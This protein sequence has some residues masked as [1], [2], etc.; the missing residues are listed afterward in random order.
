MK[1]EQ[2]TAIVARFLLLLLAL[3]ACDGA[4][5]TARV[6]PLWGSPHVDRHHYAATTQS[7]VLQQNQQQQQQP[8]LGAFPFEQA[9]TAAQALPARPQAA[10][11]STHLLM[12]P[13]FSA[14]APSEPVAIDVAMTM[15]SRSH[16]FQ[17]QRPFLSLPLLFFGDVPSA[18]YD[19]DTNPIAA[20]DADGRSLKLVY[21]DKDPVFGP[22]V[23]YMD[24][25]ETTPSALEQVVVRFLA[26]YR[27]MENDTRSGARVDLRRDVS[28]TG[29]VGQGVSFIPVP[30]STDEDDD[31]DPV[32]GGDWDVT[33]EWDLR[34]APAQSANIRGAWSHGDAAVSV[35][36]GPLIDLV[37]NAI[38]A[39]GALRRY[40]DW[41]PPPPHPAAGKHVATGEF[42]VY[43]L[44]PAPLNVTALAVQSRI[45]H[46]RI[47]AYFDAKDEPFRVFFRQVEEGN[48]G[49]G[50][51][52]SFIVEFSEESAEYADELSFE[53]LLSHETVHEYA[54]LDEVPAGKGNPRWLMDES[55]WYI[56]G[57]ADWLTAV[58]GMNPDAFHRGSVGDAAAATVRRRGLTSRQV[59]IQMLNDLAQAYYTAPAGVQR[60]DFGEFLERYFDLPIDVNLV[61]V[62]YNRGF[63]F[64]AQLDGMIVSATDGRH[65]MD[66]VI[67]D[68]YRRRKEGVKFTIDDFK[69]LLA[70]YVGADAFNAAY[71]A[72]FKG[73]LIVPG[74]HSLRGLGLRRLG[75]TMKGGKV[76]EVVP[77]SNAERA[78]VRVGDELVRQWMVW[79]VEDRLDATMKLTVLR[80]GREIEFE[81]IPRSSEV[82]EA[83]GWARWEHWRALFALWIRIRMASDLVLVD[84][85]SHFYPR[86]DT[87]DTAAGGDG[88]PQSDNASGFTPS[89][90]DRHTA[91][92]AIAAGSLVDERTGALLPLPDTS[93]ES[94]TFHLAAIVLTPENIH[95]AHTVAALSASTTTAA[96][97]AMLPCAG[98]HPVQTIRVPADAATPDGSTT[99]TVAADPRLVPALLRLLKAAPAPLAAVGEIGLDF[100]PWVLA[101]SV[102]LSPA[103]PAPPPVDPPNDAD[104][105]SIP[106]PHI[107]PPWPTA[108]AVKAAQGWTLRTQALA[109]WR[110]GLPVNV[111]SR[112]A[113]HHAIDLLLDL[114]AT[115]RPPATATATSPQKHTPFFPHCR[116]LSVPATVVRDDT[117]RNWV[118]RVGV[119]ALVLESDAPA[120]PPTREQARAWPKQSVVVACVEVAR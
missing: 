44:E 108:D 105:D 37:S 6:T 98:I 45:N 35:A 47:A 94:S 77:G 72:F 64:I 20:F 55:V 70:S 8:I 63:T 52:R 93:P 12:R 41:T 28:R 73:D 112:N 120:L 82:V 75:Y 104:R 89:E 4:V 115:L 109:A 69:Q 13:V 1:E 92:R 76:V 26:P 46:A 48:G 88:Y 29:L 30:P 22:R 9:N 39:V 85:H 61:R 19:S 58:V 95:E 21:V 34:S 107:L 17:P 14:T 56:E 91:S 38:F 16:P 119:D 71:E 81:W 99:A 86:G 5:A 80:E 54:L 7:S 79:L 96:A 87:S 2:A 11:P 43:W 65:C 59:M 40:P 50:S 53:A 113:G 102:R 31:A 74:E 18:R 118:R 15:T 84:C 97:V 110:R 10:L 67:L 32:F 33:V 78:G 103:L 23:W 60:M 36:R 57:V 3:L 49:T 100:S 25:D 117:T 42:A 90:I 111:H 62:A 51:T 116:F 27:R 66:D 83:Y 101:N 68:V 24:D 106:P 114:A